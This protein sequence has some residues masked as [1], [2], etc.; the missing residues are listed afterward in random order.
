MSLNLL[1]EKIIIILENLEYKKIFIFSNIANDLLKSLDIRQPFTRI[2][3]I[4]KIE[5][6]ID[7]DSM[8]L[9]ILDEEAFKL[10]QINTL[11]TIKTFHQDKFIIINRYK[12]EKKKVDFHNTLMSFGFKLLFTDE[13]QKIFYDI[14][15]YNIID[16]KN[17]PEWLNSDYWANPELWEK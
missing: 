3:S 8:L 14:Y 4:S 15:E 6:S 10:E 11:A 2:D 1:S 7:D 12:K 16:Y 9:M 5:Q 17:K 13:F